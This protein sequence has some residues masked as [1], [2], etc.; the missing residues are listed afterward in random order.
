MSRSR[1]CDTKFATFSGVFSG[2]S[3]YTASE[4]SV[5]A[6]LLSGSSCGDRASTS[7]FSAGCT[8]DVT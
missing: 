1:I 7:R 4:L 2:A 3:C 8:G 5:R 6:V